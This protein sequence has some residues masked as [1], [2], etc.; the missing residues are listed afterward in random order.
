MIKVKVTLVQALRLCTGR[1]VYRRSRGIALPFL[2]HGT[3][4]GLGEGSAS[5]PGRSFSPGKTRYPLYRRLGGSQGWSGQV[6]K[7]SPPT[8]IR[9]P[10]RPARSQSRYRLR[11]PAHKRNVIRNG[12]N[13]KKDFG[14]T[15]SWCVFKIFPHPSPHFARKN[16][17]MSVKMSVRIFRSSTEIR[18]TMFKWFSL[19][20]SRCG[21]PY[22]LQIKKKVATLLSVKQNL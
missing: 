4:R 14:R 16:W 21:C 1:T 8:G 17:R 20:A 22:F 7:I 6:R 5:R 9:S 15:W 13:R 19:R 12:R 10:D 3:R 18:K 11:Y 2:D